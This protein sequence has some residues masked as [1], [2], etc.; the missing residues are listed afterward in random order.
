MYKPHKPPR[1]NPLYRRWFFKRNSNPELENKILVATNGL[2]EVE[3][4]NLQ[5]DAKAAEEALQA[6]YTIYE[7]GSRK[8]LPG[9]LVYENPGDWV[10][11]WHIF[12][13]T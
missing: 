13:C 2:F 12:V 11:V 6:Q 4:K 9:D 5:E 1:E 8:S 10:F 3:N 7:L